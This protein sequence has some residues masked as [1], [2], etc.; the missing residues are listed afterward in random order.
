MSV[1][2]VKTTSEFCFGFRCDGGCG[3]AELLALTL[4]A[5]WEA[6]PVAGGALV[7]RCP[8]CRF[9]LLVEPLE[10]DIAWREAAW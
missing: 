4:P 5:G 3:R 8:D 10:A 7:H 1:R 9:R 2:L 6:L